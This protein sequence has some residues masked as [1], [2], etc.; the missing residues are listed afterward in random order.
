MGELKC[1]LPNIKSLMIS[2][3][4]SECAPLTQ[5][6]LHCIP[7]SL[8]ELS[9]NRDHPFPSSLSDPYCSELVKA[10]SW[11]TKNVDLHELIMSGATMETIVKA[12]S[13]ANSLAF[14]CCKIQSDDELD[15]SGPNYRWDRS[16]IYKL[17]WIIA[18]S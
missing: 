3:L 4:F 7:D 12:S 17:K 16:L 10:V 15:F 11:V 18:I 5:F 13:Q 6:L 14:V 1:R 2:P 8:I 9:I